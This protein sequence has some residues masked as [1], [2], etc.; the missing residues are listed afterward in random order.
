[1]IIQSLKNVNQSYDVNM[2]Y[3]YVNIAEVS[4]SKVNEPE[5]EET[6]QRVMTLFP[7]LNLE[8]LRFA[9]NTLV[10]TFIPAI[11]KIVTKIT[12]EVNKVSSSAELTQ[13]VWKLFKVTILE[14]EV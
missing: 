13:V 8:A 3:I 14:D 10:P 9:A 4:L 7:A 6:D 5:Q 2:I 11:L 12:S 1:M